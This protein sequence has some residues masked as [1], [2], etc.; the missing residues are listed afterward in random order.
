[1]GNM[2]CTFICTNLIRYISY[3]LC[4]AVV[5]GAKGRSEEEI[6]K[7][8]KIG[9]R[10]L[11]GRRRRK[12]TLCPRLRNVDVKLNDQVSE[13]FSSNPQTMVIRNVWPR[14]VMLDID[15]VLFSKGE[16]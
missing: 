11:S 8:I 15:G 14:P 6:K 10:D 16:K 3:L 4:E 12:S 1:M 9:G 2:V 7:Y 5:Q 13:N